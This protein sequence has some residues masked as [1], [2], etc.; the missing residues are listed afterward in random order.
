MVRLLAKNDNKVVV[1][2]C[3]LGAMMPMRLSVNQHDDWLG[4]LQGHNVTCRSHEWGD[5]MTYESLKK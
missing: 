4:D 5:H 2:E 1:E 3:V